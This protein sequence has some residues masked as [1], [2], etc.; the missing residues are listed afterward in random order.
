MKRKLRKIIQIAP[1]PNKFSPVTMWA[2][3][4]DGTIWEYYIGQNGYQWI[5]VNTDVIRPSQEE[6]S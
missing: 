2:L 6:S 5:E 4:D 1:C 3:C